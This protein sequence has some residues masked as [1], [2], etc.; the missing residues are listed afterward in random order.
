[1]KCI[2][3]MSIAFRRIAAGFVFRQVQVENQ[4]SA[5]AG[6]PAYRLGVSPPFV[7]DDDPEWQLAH[8]EQHALIAWGIRSIFTRVQLDLVLIAERFAVWSNNECGQSK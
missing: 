1:M 4:L 2:G 3:G 5:T 7:A 6:S 8:L